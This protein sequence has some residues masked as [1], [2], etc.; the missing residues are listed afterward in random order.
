MLDPTDRSLLFESLRP[1]IG[2]SLD[3]AVGTTYSLDLL[4]LLAAPLAFALFD[5]EDKEGGP[6]MDPLALLEALRRNADN[7][8]IFCQ[9]GRIK[10]PPRD[11]RLLPYLEQVV[12]EVRA[13]IEGGTFHPK[14][15]VLRFVT[16]DGPV[17]YR[18]LCMSRNLTFDR[19][20]DTVLCLEGEVVERKNAF[21][22]NRP[23]SAFVAA[24]PTFV[25]RRPIPD[26]TQKTI[27]SFQDELMRV[28]FEPPE[29]FDQVAFWP[30]GL[31]GVSRWPFG[32]RID[33]LMI[34]SPFIAAT[35]LKRLGKSGEGHI[36][37]SRLDEL[38]RLS[39]TALEP[40]ER[41][42]ALSDA[43]DGDAHDA[44]ELPSPESALGD[45]NLLGLHAKLYV[46]DAGWGARIWSGSAN[47]TQ[48]AFEK[49]VEFLVELTG[50]KSSCGVDAF[51]GTEKN[52]GGFLNLLVP[53]SPAESPVP[54]DP[55]QQHM[56]E[57]LEETRRALASASLS[58]RAVSDE[59]NKSYQLRLESGEGPLPPIPAGLSIRAWPITLRPEAGVVFKSGADPVCEFGQVSFEALTS[60]FALE[61]TLTYEGRTCS[62]TFVLNI[63][64]IGAPEDRPQR[65]LLSLLGDRQKFLRF[66]ALLLAGTSIDAAALVGADGAD[67]A[68]NGAGGGLEQGL[69]ETLI[70]A[71]DHSPGKLDQVSRLI[72]DLGKTEDG[73]RVLPEGLTSVWKPIW[74]ARLK[75]QQ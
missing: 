52:G 26:R 13:P 29:G 3:R 70:R 24:L 55:I 21:A 16:S 37:V 25:T 5:W 56:E 72:T 71:L 2:Y 30:L 9:A 6:M 60:F 61:L 31:P 43:A 22:A 66:L 57:V 17:R 54:V 10:L 8:S 62:I 28:R 41:V 58:A 23:L 1:P 4:T 35:T 7:L 47:A 49:N 75:L 68:H 38:A 45:D 42:Y 59:A 27:E 36:L 32:G 65:I 48:A 34:V 69:L 33:R 18:V 67:A 44:E 51:L 63:P 15:W 74:A 20:W 12:F 73:R 64:L 50:R 14:M 19:S 46:A 53:F 40:F 39:K 11:Q